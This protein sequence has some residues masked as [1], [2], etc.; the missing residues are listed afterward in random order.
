M[1]YLLASILALLC[2]LYLSA[3]ARPQETAAPEVSGSPAPVAG[4]RAQPIA[5]S[6]PVASV[7]EPAAPDEKIT[8]TPV[9]TGASSSPAE[10]ISIQTTAASESEIVISGSFAEGTLPESSLV[11]QT[12]T[13]PVVIQ[14]TPRGEIEISPEEKEALEVDLTD[15]LKQKGSF[16]FV[17]EDL[18]VVLRS[19]AKAY[20]FNVTLAPEVQGKVTVDYKDVMVVNALETI[21]KDHGFGYQIS[22]NILRVT[23]MEK[24]KTEEEALSVRREAEAKTSVAEA[25]KLKAQE[26]AEPLETKV[27]ILKYIDANDAMEAIKSLLTKDRGKIMIMKTKQFKGF[28]W[29]IRVSTS[30]KA[31]KAPEDYVRSRTLI[32]QDTGTVLKQVESVLKQIDQ[33][34][35]QVLIDAKVIEVPIDQE[36]RLGIDWTQALNRW[37]VGA[38]NLQMILTKGYSQEDNSVN[39]DTTNR[40][41]E[42]EDLAQSEAG[43]QVQDSYSDSALNRQVNVRSQIFDRVSGDNVSRVQ[44][45][46]NLGDYINQVITRSG[47]GMYQNQAA[48]SADIQ[49]AIQESRFSD[50]AYDNTSSTVSARNFENYLDSIANS[51]TRIATAG[52]S[53][54]AV[55]SAA[56][57]NLMLS[58]MKTDS[59][60]V[61]LSNPRVIVQENYAAKIHV[62][63]RYPIISTE[64][65][66]S[67]GAGEEGI[68]GG[69]IGGT[70]I[71]DWLE[72]GITLKVIPQIR[73]GPGGTKSI[74]MIVHPAVSTKQA[75]NAITYAPN[76]QQV[77]SP[78]PIVNIRESD[79]NVNL[80]NGDTLVIGGMIQSES[81]D[82][83]KKIP[84]LGD[85]PIL[86]YLFKEKHTA[87]HKTNILIFITAKIV[88]EQKLSAY[89]KLMLEK[90]TPDALQDV[91]YTEDE[92]IRPFLYKSAKE[93]PPPTPVPSPSPE[94]ERKKKE[95]T[96]EVRKEGSNES[97]RETEAS[98]RSQLR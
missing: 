38:G 59:N 28:E 82:E 12:G 44:D 48:W 4:E 74:N 81:I 45:T 25:A 85:I 5:A 79:T 34:P 7:A 47:E 55:I 43:R 26:Q 46:Y 77:F 66:S 17:D 6:S 95:S 89:E 63:Q 92:N 27:Y 93:P 70:S 91:N 32:V 24:I 75:N 11:Q 60:I 56:D 22:G 31:E 42:L 3:P 67:G 16:R 21:L 68:G 19:L 83:E 71:E 8:V 61:V 20:G 72:I 69:A 39:S 1:K 49:D 10:G 9:E 58:A 78:Y 62:G 76:G 41:Y 23:T 52:E 80:N 18:R 84:L 35:S 40:G 15:K 54:N 36:F 90:A 37:Q 94:P 64:F 13:K 97:R 86:G 14:A 33:R 50:L 57:F 73:E 29:E 98:K 87:L 2:V 96:G 30:A 88:D 65:T 51:L 53:Y